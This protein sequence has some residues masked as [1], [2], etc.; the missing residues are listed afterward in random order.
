MS[1]FYMGNSIQRGV[2]YHF[3]H[4]NFDSTSTKI[5]RTV[6]VPKDH[7]SSMQTLISEMLPFKKKKT[8][9]SVLTNSEQSTFHF[10]VQKQLRNTQ[11]FRKSE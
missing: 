8:I 10:Y 5:K 1:Q 11:E 4:T 3:T 9:T 2:L 7:L 6:L